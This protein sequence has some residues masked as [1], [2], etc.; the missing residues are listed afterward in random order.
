MPR[1]RHILS[2]YVYDTLNNRYG[3]SISVQP[4]IACTTFHSFFSWNVWKKFFFKIFKSWQVCDW[5]AKWIIMLGFMD[6]RWPRVF[7][8]SSVGLVITSNRQWLYCIVDTS[9]NHVHTTAASYYILFITSNTQWLYCIVDTSLNHEHTIAASYYI[10]FITSN[11][12]WLYCIVDTSLNHEHTIAA[13]YYILFIT[14]SRQW[15]YYIV[16]TSLKP[17]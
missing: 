1:T 7:R 3:F 5:L 2:V 10:L 12:Q 15:L 6:L 16:D 9:L 8:R 17:L 14:S 4:E 13:S 11:T